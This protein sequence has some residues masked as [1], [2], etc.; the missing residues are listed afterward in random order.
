MTNKADHMVQRRAA[1]WL[2]FRLLPS[3]FLSHHLRISSFR[4]SFR[5]HLLFFLLDLILICNL[6]LPHLHNPFLRPD[7]QHLL[8]FPLYSGYK[9]K[10]ESIEARLSLDPVEEFEGERVELDLF[11][12]E[13]GKV[14]AEGRESD[15]FRFCNL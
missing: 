12:A 11:R 6:H 7:T 4:Y 10:L 2:S 9:R 8:L 15:D 3:F 14:G 1:Y 5:L 13:D